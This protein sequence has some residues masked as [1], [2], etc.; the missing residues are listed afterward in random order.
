[1]S[2]EQKPAKRINFDDCLRVF[3]EAMDHKIPLVV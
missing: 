2:I 3:A 1:M